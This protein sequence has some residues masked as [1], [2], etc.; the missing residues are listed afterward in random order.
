MRQGKSTTGN[1]VQGS[2]VDRQSCKNKKYIPKCPALE[3]DEYIEMR[4]EQ[5]GI[6]E[7]GDE[8]I[9]KK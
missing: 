5:H 1:Q 3:L 6:E 4:K 7:A 2:T 8:D 9:E